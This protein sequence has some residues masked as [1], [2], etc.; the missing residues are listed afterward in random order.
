MLLYSDRE[1]GF[2]GYRACLLSKIW[3]VLDI[4]KRRMH[5]H[6]A[7]A[8]CPSTIIGQSF[9][10]AQY[11]LESL[12]LSGNRGRR[13]QSWLPKCRIRPLHGASRTYSQ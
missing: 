4:L 3:F 10:T 2:L 13:I 5:R 8:F 6:N 1:G 7:C 12:M 9:C 11:E